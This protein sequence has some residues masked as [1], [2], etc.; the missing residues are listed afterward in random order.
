M[1]NN[2]E[3]IEKYICTYNIENSKIHRFLDKIKFD[4]LHIKKLQSTLNTRTT[5]SHIT[6]QLTLGF[7]IKKTLL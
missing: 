3:Q 2:N 7:F 6:T 4:I 5:C 1:N